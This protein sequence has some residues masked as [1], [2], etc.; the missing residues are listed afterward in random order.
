VVAL[1]TACRADAPKLDAGE[2]EST[3]GTTTSSLATS[4][5]VSDTTAPGTTTSA[6]DASTGGTSQGT[7]TGEAADRF[8]NERS[9]LIT[10]HGDAEFGDAL[11]LFDRQEKVGALSFWI[12]RV[13]EPG[14][15]WSADLR[16][17][18]SFVAFESSTV[19]VCTVNGCDTLECAPKVG[20]N[21]HEWTH[22]VVTHDERG[23]RLYKNGAWILK[24][25]VPLDPGLV[26]IS[27]SSMLV[28]EVAI[29]D[30][31]L[32][33]AEVAAVYNNGIPSDLEVPTDGYTAAD[34]LTHYWRMGDTEAPFANTIPDE[35][36]DAPV[37]LPIGNNS[38][39]TDVP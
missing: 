34:A 30:R 27:S 6:P 12:K 35:I 16:V 11:E 19:E 5:D 22:V 2:A 4:S 10:G 21:A 31:P 38:F 14:V 32:T 24:A 9:V 3:A 18:C 25:F 23:G 37:S 17:G 15:F 36:G 33:P 39:S 7:S 26:G 29:W 20:L 8:P 13:P 28:D 1:I